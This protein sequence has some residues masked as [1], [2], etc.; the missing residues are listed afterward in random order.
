MIK[1]LLCLIIGHEYREYY[2]KE[3]GKS[4]IVKC[5]RCGKRGY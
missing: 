2:F 1:K 4:N 3:Q 5:K